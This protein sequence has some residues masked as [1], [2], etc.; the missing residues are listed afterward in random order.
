MEPARRAPLVKIVE[1]AADLVARGNRRE[2]RTVM[3]RTGFRAQGA[4]DCAGVT[5]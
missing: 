3:K 4:L 1:I 2:A 5:S